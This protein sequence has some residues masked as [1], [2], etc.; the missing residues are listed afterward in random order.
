MIHYQHIVAPVLRHLRGVDAPPATRTALDLLLVG[1]LA[2]ADSALAALPA[3]S[4][5]LCALGFI[6]YQNRDGDQ[7]LALVT[8]AAESAPVAA[9]V[10]AFL[11]ACRLAA[12]RY[13]QAIPAL[14][15][16]LRQDS[17]LHAA[18][19]LLW[20]ALDGAGAAP[21]AITA[22]K[23]ELL[24]LWHASPTVPASANPVE[25][26]HTTLLVLD[27][28]NHALAQRALALSLSGCCFEHV[29]WLTDRMIVVPGVETVV[30]APIL[31]HA[32]YSRFMVKELLAY[33]DTDHVLVVQWDGHVVNPAAWSPEFLLFDYIGARWDNALHR[34]AAH[35][36]VG[37]GGFS[38]R[39]RA[40]LEALQ[41]PAIVVTSAEDVTICRQYRN[42]LED[43]HGIV[44]APDD[45]ADRFAFEH[46][47]QPSMPF[48]FHSVSNLARFVGAPGW[49]TLDFHFR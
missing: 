9:I 10:Q 46:L 38:L 14:R 19:T 24:A 28:A 45:I 34:K 48:G 36:N 40:L 41:D 42:F 33:V 4:T 37:N 15:D 49:A 7:A 6:A 1:D 27:H 11:G 5:T 47:E 31:S 3:D 18:H 22:L 39:S 26:E 25:I 16:A 17:T 21:A 35:H 12:G 20:S 44:F 43:R 23:A 32:D 2:G 29:K 30:T 13:E 8:R